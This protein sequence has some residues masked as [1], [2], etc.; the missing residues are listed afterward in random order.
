MVESVALKVSVKDFPKEFEK[1]AKKLGKEFE[2]AV[3]EAAVRN[4]PKLVEKSPVDTGEYA[5]S[6]E[7]EFIPGEKVIIGNF[8]PHA[9]VI[10]FGAR[11]FTP[12]IRPL[13]AW[14]KRVLQDPSQ[15]PN[16]SNRVWGLAKAVQKKIMVKG[17]EPKRILTNQLPEI[18]K[19][20][21]DIVLNE[22]E[23]DPEKM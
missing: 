8:A 22:M 5:S 3:A 19:D 15:P 4:I 11:P 6:W 23:K 20:I 21:I 1:Y 7:T 12:P 14:A 9:T 10:E 18:Q 13:L 16:Y 17:M 2:Q